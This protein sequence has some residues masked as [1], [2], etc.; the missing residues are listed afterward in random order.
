MKV[1]E[2]KMVTNVIRLQVL[3]VHSYSQSLLLS[4]LMH[5]ITYIKLR[6]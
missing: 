3:T 6:D 5:S 4:V 1:F 2:N